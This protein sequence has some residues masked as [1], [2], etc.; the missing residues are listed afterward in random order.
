MVYKNIDIFIKLIILVNISINICFSDEYVSFGGELFTMTSDARISA[1]GGNNP[2]LSGSS[3]Q[4]FNNPALSQISQI[5]D[6][7]FS[8]R[9]QFSGLADVFLFSAPIRI[10]NK[11]S[12]IGIIHRSIKDIPYTNDAFELIDGSP[13]LI[14]YNLITTFDH[15]ELGFLYSISKIFYKYLIGINIKTLFYSIYT[16][17]AF[18]LGLDFGSVWNINSNTVMGVTL[19]DI[20][21][22]IINWTTDHTEFIPMRISSG[23]T[24]ANKN[25]L[26]AGMFKTDESILN[27]FEVLD[28]ISL[29][30]EYKIYSTFSLR[31][32]INSQKNISRDYEIMSSF[33]M[34]I[35]QSP[36]N[37]DYAYLISPSNSPFKASHELT[38]GI[39]IQEIHK[40][41]DYIKP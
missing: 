12:S 40:L 4:I 34:G 8:Y 29:G 10:F 20:P 6:L 26:I 25:W 17:K 14:D 3:G 38:I 24:Y 2:S 21:I 36:I 19:H 16:E 15:T 22:T 5:N 35:K 28:R 33:G 31:C 37:L 9:N 27:N 41:S 13:N 11:N 23:V 32:G 39:D 7:T 18:G 30:I 1:L